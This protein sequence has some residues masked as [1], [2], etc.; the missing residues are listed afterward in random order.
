LPRRRD[1]AR[2][3]RLELVICITEG[4]PVRDMIRTRYKMQGKRTRLIGPNCPGLKSRT[5]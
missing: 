5:S 3:T 1:E 4:I 2:S